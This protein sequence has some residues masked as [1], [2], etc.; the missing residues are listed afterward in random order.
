MEAAVGTWDEMCFTFSGFV[1]SISSIKLA[2]AGSLEQFSALRD[3][4][5]RFDCSEDIYPYVFEMP[6]YK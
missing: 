5:E 2:S 1:K 3:Y 6:R 4:L